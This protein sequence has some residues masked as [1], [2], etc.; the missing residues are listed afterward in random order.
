MYNNGTGDKVRV[1]QLNYW[2]EGAVGGSGGG[3]LVLTPGPSIQGKGRGGVVHNSMGWELCF[4]SNW[5]ESTSA[6]LNPL[7]QGQR[8]ELSFP[9]M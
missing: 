6:M 2:G 4:R 1:K 7:L 3:P 9:P 8:G 5:S